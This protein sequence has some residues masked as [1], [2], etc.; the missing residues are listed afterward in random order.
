MTNSSDSR[1]AEIVRHLESKGLRGGIVPLSRLDASRQAVERAYRSGGMGDDY[2]DPGIEDL[3]ATP[4]PGWSGSVWVVAVPC[5]LLDLAFN[6]G[7]GERH[8]V[9]AEM[10]RYSLPM[11]TAEEAMEAAHAKA[12]EICEWA[13]L[14]LRALAGEA[15][16]GEYGRNNMLYM[17]GLGS[18]PWLAGFFSSISCPGEWRTPKRMD[19]CA[20]CG[21]CVDACPSGALARDRLL[22][23]SDRCLNYATDFPDRCRD[24][25][26]PEWRKE[27]LGCLACQLACPA[28]AGCARRKVG[29]T[30]SAGETEELMAAATPEDLSPAVVEKLGDDLMPYLEVIRDRLVHAFVS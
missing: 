27:L 30:F 24:W 15:G 21:R 16:L 10:Y 8:I 1:A 18:Y 25:L 19:R 2:V 4:I 29:Q 3:L 22:M 12:G 28:N 23:R 17:P 9:L 26:K 20:G 5:A 11:R 7:G 6:C 14:P 13:W